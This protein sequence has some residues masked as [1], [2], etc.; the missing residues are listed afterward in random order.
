MAWFRKKISSSAVAAD[1]ADKLHGFNEDIAGL[2]AEAGE[3]PAVPLLAVDDREL[4][5]FVLS[6]G[7]LA[8]ESSKLTDSERETLIPQTLAFYAERMGITTARYDEFS[9]FA[10]ERHR[11]YAFGGDGKL[12]PVTRMVIGLVTH[13]DV[14][15]TQHKML[16]VVLT[17]MLTGYAES[18][19]GL[20]NDVHSEFKLV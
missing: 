18:L 6:L 10:I 15:E 5:A 2:W 14:A 20:L 19:I 9:R 3:P 4:C 12:H 1:L 7:M 13:H 11:E 16:V 17:P 8:F